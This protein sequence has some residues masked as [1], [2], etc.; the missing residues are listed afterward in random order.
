MHTT[1]SITS[2]LQMRTL[3][4]LLS[5]GQIHGASKWQVWIRTQVFPELLA[6]LTYFCERMRKVNRIWGSLQSVCD[7][8]VRKGRSRSEGS[9]L[10]PRPWRCSPSALI[11]HLP[12][13]TRN[14][15]LL[16]NPAPSL[17]DLTTLLRIPA[18]AQL[19]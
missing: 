11:T 10:E 4:N 17:E 6:P 15:P 5:L 7:Q 18:L 3:R 13:Y 2:I 1:I 12:S 14:T 8:Y 19:M 16:P 9:D